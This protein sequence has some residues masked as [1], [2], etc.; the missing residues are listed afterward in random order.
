[1]DFFVEMVRSGLKPAT[2]V[3]HVVSEPRDINENGAK[4]KAKIQKRRERSKKGAG[5]PKT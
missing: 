5:S 4:G 2:D 3:R 1:V